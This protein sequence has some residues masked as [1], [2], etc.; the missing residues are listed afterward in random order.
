MHPESI[1]AR[2]CAKIQFYNANYRVF[3]ELHVKVNTFFWW[4]KLSHRAKNLI[5]LIS[6]LYINENQKI[7]HERTENWR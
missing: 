5:C 7:F 4:K 6:K 3:T 2:T 1:S